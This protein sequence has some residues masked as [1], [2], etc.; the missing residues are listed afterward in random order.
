MEAPVNGHTNSNVIADALTLPSGNAGTVQNNTYNAAT[1]GPVTVFNLTNLSMS[2]GQMVL[3]GVQGAGD[4]FI[5]NISGSLSLSGGTMILK[6]IDASHV[7]FIANNISISGG[8]VDGTFYDS[9]SSG[10]I[11]MSGG[12]LTGPLVGGNGGGLSV[13]GGTITADPFA[14][15]QTIARRT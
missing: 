6:N 4:T 15:G 3:N 11:S 12:N 1:S 13:S 10:H 9:S 7:I 14:S 2:G 8:T 5:F